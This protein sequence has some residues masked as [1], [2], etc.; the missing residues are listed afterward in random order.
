MIKRL[1][2]VIL[3]FATVM[4]LLAKTSKMDSLSLQM[5]ILEQRIG[6]EQQDIAVVQKELGVYEKEMSAICEHVDRANE[7][8]SNQ[9]AASSHTIQVWGWIIAILAIVVTIFASVAG[10]LF[11]RYINKIRKDISHLT[12]E[13]NDQLQQAEDAFT[14]IS[15]E[16]QRVNAQQQE[17][18]KIQEDTA[19]KLHELQNLHSE[20]QN[21]M[22]AIYEKMKREETIALLKRLEE[23]PEDITNVGDI[24]L[25]RQFVSSDFE[26]MHNAYHN[27]IFHSLELSGLTS[28]SELRRSDEDFR[29]LEGSYI[30]QF[31]QHFMGEAIVDKELQRLLRPSFEALFSD[32]FFRNDAEKST[33][34]FKRG[35]TTLESQL[36][37]S[38]MIDY[39][40]AISKSRFAKFEELYTILLADLAESQLEEIWNGV[41]KDNV[42][43]I[44]FAQTIKDLITTLNPQSTMLNGINVYINNIEQQNLSQDI[45]AQ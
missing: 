45:E 31:A 8:I 40:L 41:T 4:T 30:L 18:K 33:V 37:S 16:Q 9:I 17:V 34:D 27:L 12:S 39:I 14:D 24:L 15:E 29:I 1:T 38:L 2:I 6:E 11:A 35:V 44:F 32:C 23:I 3:L 43:A 42:N 20:I 26:I 36:Q 7:E 19:K 5:Q 28:L 21:N 25:T 10:A 22:S 13:A